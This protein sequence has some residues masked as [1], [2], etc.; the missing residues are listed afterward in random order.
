MTLLKF[1]MA[2]GDTIG[3]RGPSGRL[4]YLGNGE[5]SIKKLRKDPP[6]TVKVTNVNLIAGGTGITPML[7][8]IRDILKRTGDS[9]KLKL[10]FA[11]QTEDDILLR[12]EIEEVAAKHPDQFQF[13]YTLDRP[14]ANWQ[15]SEGFINDTMLSAHLF[16]PG[17]D[18]LT[19]MCGPPPMVNYACIPALEKL[20][21]ASDKY[22]AY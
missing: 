4:Q 9:T 10:L 1:L 3:F 12:P 13:W 2:L 22:F 20:G 7:Q 18:T 17:D 14:A 19:L 5:F 15:Y 16:A 11:N 6:I 8:L 21:H